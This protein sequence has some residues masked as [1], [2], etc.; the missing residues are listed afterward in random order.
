M[1]E[2]L[3]EGVKG[4]IWFSLIDKVYRERSLEVSWHKVKANGGSA[5]SDHQSVQGFEEQLEGNLKQLHE[6]LRAGSYR[7][8]PIR[9]Q[10][11]EK[12]GSREKRALGI[13]A[14]RD[15]VVQGALRLAIEPIFE[16][17]FA[18]C[19]YGFRPGRSC[20]DALREAQRLLDSGHSWVVDADL[21]AYFDSI[22]HE[23][24]MQEVGRHIADSRVLELI[25]AFLKQGILEPLGQWQPE[26]GTPQGAVISPLLANLYLHPVDEAMGQAGFAMV[27]YA[28]DLVILCRSQRQ[29]Q[30]ALAQLERLVAE[31]GLRLHPEKT[32][33]V[34]TQQADSSFEFL[35]YRFAKGSRWPRG[36]SLKKLKEAIRQ[37][38]RR[39][40][41]RSLSE[42]VGGVNRTLRGWFEYFKHS[43]KWTFPAIDGWTRR[44]LRSILRR[45]SKQKG[46]SGGTDHQRW[47]NRYFRDRGLFCL[48]ETHR[49]LLQSS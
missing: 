37:Q 23:Q 9:R 24:L 47:P 19:S 10:Y 15:R 43:N 36:K 45:R 17:R 21:K 11:I 6:E 30:A 12:A 42:I 25:E 48:E 31:R 35:G 49:S 8:R 1:L 18:P 13:P 38:T 4:G 41:G 28:D 33:V 27:R 26:A 7:P 46:I 44:R 3:E 5:G 2:A 16:R 40:S 14:V 32:R 20:K 29:A 34:D 39:T 22:P